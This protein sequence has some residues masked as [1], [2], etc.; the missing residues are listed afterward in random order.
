[1][2][3]SLIPLPVISQPFERIAM[4]IVGPLKSHRGNQFVLVICDYATCY[5]EAFPLKHIDAAY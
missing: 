1:M 5:P 3:A 2:K 4:D